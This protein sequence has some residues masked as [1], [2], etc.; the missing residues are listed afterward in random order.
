MGFNSLTLTG[1]VFDSPYIVMDQ[2]VFKRRV[3]L[4]G[5]F[6]LSIACFF[7]YRLASLHFSD[8]IRISSYKLS[9][10]RRGYIKDRN[11]YI[12]AISIEKNSLFAN[13]KEISDPRYVAERLSPVIGLTKEFIFSRVNRDKRFVWIKRKIDDEEVIR[14]KAL[15]L[16]GLHFK[17]EYHRVYPHGRL[18]SNILGFVDIDNNGLEGI[19]YGFN[20]ILLPARKSALSGADDERKFNNII[21]TIDRYIQYTSEKAIRQA[22]IQNK[23]SQGAA[24]VLEVKTGNILAIAKYPD[25]DPNYYYRFSQKAIGNFTV[26]N[27]FEP[28][29]TLKII[30]L[31]AILEK[32]P[33]LLRKTF[34]CTGS[35]DIG[36]VTVNC[37]KAHGRVSLH[38]IITQS[39]NTGIIQAMK[40]IS[41]EDSFTVLENFGF[42]KETGVNLPGES[43]GILRPVKEWSGLSKYSIAIGQEISVTSLQLAA[44]FGAI[45]NGGIYIYP[46]IIKRVEGDRGN[47]IKYYS[48]RVKG[49]VISKKNSEI[50]LKMMRSVVTDGTGRM[51]D[52]RYYSPA[53]KTGTGQKFLRKGGY[54][55]QYVASFIGIAPYNDPDICVLVVLDEPEI[56]IYGGEVA[57]PVFSRIAERVLVYRG[58]K[59]NKF[60]AQEPREKGGDNIK[61]NDDLM[62]DFRGLTMAQ[63][64]KLLINIQSKMIVDYSFIGNGSVYK[65]TPAPGV[66]LKGKQEIILYLRD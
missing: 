47:V 34:T 56:S 44:A 9:D 22:V 14:I 65:Q 8:K 26:V 30:A 55:G 16:K 66:R 25:F 18:A 36:D 31:A 62:P 53:G 27:S 11:G 50:I 5:L 51:A 21:L 4:T 60:I 41:R 23:A 37:G 3:L 1:D 58:V 57:A 19:E 32:K 49:R 12:L 40:E 13:P 33:G 38:D 28:G 29:S 7:I 59:I 63:S 39:C 2:K 24:V 42:G 54:Y 17:K 64:L 35:I 15:N 61:F 45:A 20:D 10:T 52:I 48:P 6:I 43:R 46:S